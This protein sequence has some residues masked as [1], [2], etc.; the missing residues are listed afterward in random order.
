MAILT[1]TYRPPA[2][3][4]GG[5]LQTVMPSLLRSVDAPYTRS[6]HI[7]TPDGDVLEAAWA[8]AVKTPARGAAI[9]THGLEGDIHRAY[10]CGMARALRHDGWDVLAW[11]LRGCGS[12]PNRTVPTYHSGKTEDLATVVAH[13]QSKGYDTIALV[14]FSLGG[15]LTLKY[16]GERGVTVP[17][18]VQGGVAFSTPV[19]LGPSAHRIDTWTNAHYAFYFLR[20]LRQT[21]RRKAVQ[22]P[23]AISTA[24]LGEIR[25]LVAFDDAYTAPLNGFGDAATY[26]RKAS[27]KPFLPRIERP[28]LLVNA[29]N[30]PFL[31]A[32][33]YP[34]VE[35]QDHPHFHLEVPDSGGHVGFMACSD[36]G[37]YWSEMRAAAFLRSLA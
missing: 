28:T 23:N 15:N 1:S 9:L 3:L 7:D 31:P 35:A 33:S 36:S 27:S 29:A 10:M 16:L 34:F 4:A 25:S 13:V 17:A 37:L 18:A 24:P 8:P 11:N 20:K 21:I 19:D 5:H 12:E 22:H 32:S 6:E 14:G 26:Y 2:G 30:D